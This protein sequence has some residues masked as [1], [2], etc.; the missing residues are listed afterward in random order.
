[1]PQIYTLCASMTAYCHIVTLMK[2]QSIFT[3]DGKY[4]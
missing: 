4:K 1:M 2:Q 3:Q